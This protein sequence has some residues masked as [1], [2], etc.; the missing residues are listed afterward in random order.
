MS[1]R[2]K[3]VIAT[4]ILLAG[5]IFS[6]AGMGVLALQWRWR[7]PLYAIVALLTTLWALKDEDF[8]G[9]EWLTLPILPV[10]FA[11]ANLLL[12]PLLPAGFDNIFSVAVS[13]DTSSLLSLGVQLGFLAVFV[14]GY[15]ASTLSANIYNIA[16]IR[17]IQLLRVAHS[18]GF[19]A[20]VATALLFYIV[21][22]SFHLTGLGNFWLVM[23]VS[24][25][26]IF[27]A[28]WSVKLETRIGE[29]VVISTLAATVILGEIAWIL[30]FYP[31]G[32]SLTALFLTAIFYEMVGIIQYYFDERLNTRI[33]Y[34]FVIVAVAVFL[35]TVLSAQ[36][37]T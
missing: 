24:F 35:I 8:S 31:V 30:S 15:Y 23:F 5:I 25:P 18:V 14:V 9:V 37:G 3:I 7:V 34:E 12:F 1:K 29:R 16:A 26:L 13:S 6:R 19:L 22:F 2:Q 32:I 36:W 28:L 10:M 21:L 33:A 11:V 20:T 4:F 27:Q 17:N